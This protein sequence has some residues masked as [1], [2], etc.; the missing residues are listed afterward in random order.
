MTINNNS[1]VQNQ[2]LQNDN[3]S[4]FT[5]STRPEITSFFL[6]KSGSWVNGDNASGVCSDTNLYIYFSE[7]MDNSSITL[8]TG[9][10]TSCS[11]TFQLSL[12][13]FSSCV[14][15]SSFTSWNNL[16]YFYFTPTNDLTNGNTYKVRVTTGVED[17]SG[18]SMSSNYTTDT[19]FSVSKSSCP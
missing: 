12:D 15:I 18:N 17:G 4:G 6:K 10:D 1:V 16:K 8:N 5:S 11:G 7:S 19:G 3:L 9:S 14:Q 2:T 13:S